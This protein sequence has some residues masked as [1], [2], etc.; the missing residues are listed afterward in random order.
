MIYEIQGEKEIKL[1]NSNFLNNNRKKFKLIVEN[2]LFPLIDKYKVEKDKTKFL[3]VKLLL[4]IKE[5]VDLSNMFN[6]CTYL[7]KF[8]AAT[9]RGFKLKT[10]T[11]N[12]KHT[13]IDNT[14]KLMASTRSKIDRSQ[15]VVYETSKAL[16]N[17]RG[18]LGVKFNKDKIKSN[19]YKPWEMIT[20]KCSKALKFSEDFIEKRN[21]INLSQQCLIKVYPEKF[22]SSNYNMIKCL[23]CGFQACALNI[24]ATDDDFILYDKIFFKQ[25]QGFGYVLKPEKFFSKDF[26]N[27]YDKPLYIFHMEIISLINCSKLIENAKLKVDEDG[28]LSIKIYSI[29]IKEDEKNP[30]LNCKLS[31]GTMFP[32]FVGDFPTINYNVYDYELSAIM[33][34]IKYKD[35]MV[36]RSCIPYYFMKKGFRRIPIY[37]NQ[38]F[39]EEDVYMVGFFSMQ[40]I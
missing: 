40:K 13:N 26:N 7:K 17:A 39:N 28:E 4:Y 12:K 9:D 36:G 29:G 38:C 14:S 30:E 15:T 20:L 5:K 10:K 23:S 27:F 11:L 37:N 35:K 24:Q 21:M 22:D 6:G 34:K 2:K 8:D 1:F 19:Y 18:L 32:N 16:E 25:N 3:K 31:N 33:I